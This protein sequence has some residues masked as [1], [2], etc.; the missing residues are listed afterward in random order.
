MLDLT[1]LANMRETQESAMLDQCVILSF[2]EEQMD[3]YGY[4]TPAYTEGPLIA[5][6]L[7]FSSAY[8]H[9]EAESAFT[10]KPLADATLRL[11]YGTV[12]KETDRVRVTHRFGIAEPA[13]V[14][15]EIAGLPS[16]GPSGVFVKLRRITNEAESV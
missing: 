12:I 14:T 3:A 10:Q 15:Y 2:G 1:D 7:S 8:L 6:G 9:R 5:C 11:P 16:Y 4:K 13:P